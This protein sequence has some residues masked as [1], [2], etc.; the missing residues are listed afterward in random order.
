VR[1]RDDVAVVD[2][3]DEAYEVG[4]PIALHDVI[5]S[6]DMDARQEVA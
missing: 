6:G 1:E 3:R 5:M 4:E 2:V